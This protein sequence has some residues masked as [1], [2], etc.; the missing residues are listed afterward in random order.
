MRLISAAIAAL[1]LIITAT[2]LHAQDAFASRRGSGTSWIPAAS[3]MPSHT[4]N[5]GSW[6]LQ[7]RGT[8]FGQV[9]VQSGPRGGTQAGV[10]SWG[11][12]EGSRPVGRGRFAVR[13]ML[14]LD[15][16]GVGEAGYPAL[17][18][19]GDP[20]NGVTTHDRQLPHEF[21]SELALMYDVRLTSTKHFELYV[22][23]AGEPAL[24]APAFTHRPSAMDHPMPPLGV[25]GEE[26][27]R[28]SFGVITAGLFADGWKFEASRFNGTAPNAQRF[29]IE[30]LKLDSYSAR[31]TMRPG[32][33]WSASFGLGYIHA[34]NELDPEVSANQFTATL[35]NARRI[36]AD[37][38]LMSTLTYSANKLLAEPF[39]SHSIMFETT[40]KLNAR[41]SIV[42]RAERVHK[43]A[44]DLDLGNDV[45][46]GSAF[47]SGRNPVADVT[48]GYVRE[49]GSYRGGGVAVG[50]T[51]TL[52][53]L[54]SSF[55]SSY[56]S[57]TPVGAFVFVRVRPN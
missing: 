35:M 9:D 42:A 36:R 47:G 22:A 11:S 34:P 51:G 49:V 57:S 4:T 27:P 2:P 48:L 20:I 50:A 28:T 12:V 30:K 8:I 25:H 38:K 33:A 13:T 26:S 21:L 18:Q 17:A 31:L 6:T 14:S 53:L 10:T 55:S 1:T 52:Y 37:G 54:P 32:D 56:G 7:I 44:E 16:L 46:N 45:T 40:A 29:N 41:N 19:T 15:A 23:P 43:S 24:G 5:A 39:W 3:A